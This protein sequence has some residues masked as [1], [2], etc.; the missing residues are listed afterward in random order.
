MSK[1][2][3]EDIRGKLHHS[4]TNAAMYLKKVPLSSRT[5]VGVHWNGPAVKTSNWLQQLVDDSA[6]HINKDWSKDGSGIHGWGL[7]YHVEIDQDGKVYFSNDFEDVLWHISGGNYHA[8]GVHCILGEGQVPSSAMY[9]A[10]QGVLDWLCYDRPDMPSLTKSHVYGHGECGGQYGGGPAWDNSTAC[11]GPDLLRFVRQYR[12]SA[13]PDNVP[14]QPAIVLPVLTYPG[15]FVDENGYKVGG[16]IRMFRE[17]HGGVPIFGLPMSNERP[18]MLEDGNLYTVQC[19]ERT[20]L[21]WDPAGGVQVVRLNSM[22][23]A[24]LAQLGKAA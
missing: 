7:M 18:Q 12:A 19:F 20:W 8:I 6:F 3:M 4:A 2:V 1:P 17:A 9:Y 5:H 14:A 23:E 21:Q 13:V 15:A 11:P 16:A 10:L 24:L 22:Y